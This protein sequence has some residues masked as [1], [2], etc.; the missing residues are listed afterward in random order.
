MWIH[1]LPCRNPGGLT[2]VPFKL[3]S[4][5]TSLSPGPWR[6]RGRLGARRRG[7]GA[8]GSFRGSGE[9]GMQGRESGGVHGIS[10]KLVV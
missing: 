8:D 7:V 3:C 6:T 4:V 9:V 1:V 5:M 2:E 10:G